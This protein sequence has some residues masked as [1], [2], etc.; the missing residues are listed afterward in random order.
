MARTAIAGALLLSLGACDGSTDSKSGADQPGQSGGT[1]ASEI[2]SQ[3]EAG[4]A[5]QALGRYVI[6]HSPHV[7]SGTILLDTATGKTW[8]EVQEVNMVDKPL[9]WR[10]MPQLNSEADTDAFG[11]IHG[12]KGKTSKAEAVPSDLPQPPPGYTLTTPGGTE[13]PPHK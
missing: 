13:D 5:S 10:P 12:W 4:T 7:Q 9:A 11:K 2:A 1:T 3:A 8:N 6:V